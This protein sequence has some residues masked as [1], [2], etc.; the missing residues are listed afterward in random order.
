M[1]EVGLAK[2]IQLLE[3]DEMLRDDINKHV[4]VEY[5]K[6]FRT[7]LAYDVIQDVIVQKLSELPLE[8]TKDP[9]CPDS[10]RRASQP[11]RRR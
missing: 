7:W 8:T 9:S 4:L 6:N 10:S 3:I 1:Q 5:K 11:L 2:S